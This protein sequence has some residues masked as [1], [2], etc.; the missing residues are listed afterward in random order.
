MKTF[1]KEPENIYHPHSYANAPEIEWENYNEEI[2]PASFDEIINIMC[3]LD[4]NRN[5]VMLM[6]F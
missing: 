4:K 6:V 2:S 5:H 1:F 3:D